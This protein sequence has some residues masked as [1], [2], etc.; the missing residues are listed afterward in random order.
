[1]IEHERVIEALKAISA[2]EPEAVLDAL[3][4]RDKERVFAYL[5]KRTDLVEKE[6]VIREVIEALRED[7][8]FGG[9]SLARGSSA[10]FI[11]REFGG[12]RVS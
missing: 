12:S 2:C 3:F 5:R 9:Q 6:A 8:G 1:M 4:G 10:A 11:E 7:T